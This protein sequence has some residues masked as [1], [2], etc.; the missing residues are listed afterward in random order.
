M[1]RRRPGEA[2]EFDFP[3]TASS[4]PISSIIGLDSKPSLL[5]M[6]GVRAALVLQNRATGVGERQCSLVCLQYCSWRSLRRWA[7]PLRG[8]FCT[9]RSKA[10][11][12]QPDFPVSPSA[13]KR[14]SSAPSMAK[15]KHGCC[16]ANVV[17]PPTRPQN[18]LSLLVR[19]MYTD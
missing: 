12:I 17:S 10:Q 7:L 2:E 4:R 3:K 9:L 19:R 5:Y 13:M 8:P 18:L 16:G 15:I 6:G 1:W 11:P 14:S